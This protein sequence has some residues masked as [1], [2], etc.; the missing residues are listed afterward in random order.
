MQVMVGIYTKISTKPIVAGL[1]IGGEK[2]RENFIEGWGAFVEDVHHV[3][4]R[5]YAET[6]SFCEY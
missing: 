2:I 5:H 4:V 3:H 6:F 1:L